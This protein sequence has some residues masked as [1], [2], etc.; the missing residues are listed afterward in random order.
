MVII[1]TKSKLKKKKHQGL[2]ERNKTKSDNAK[3]FKEVKSNK[4]Q[5]DNG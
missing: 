5:I 2:F 3:I 1:I 4:M